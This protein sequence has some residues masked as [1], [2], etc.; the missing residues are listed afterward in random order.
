M[1]KNARFLTSLSFVLKEKH[2]K[3]VIKKEEVSLFCRGSFPFS[4][5][6][7]VIHISQCFFK[8]FLAYVNISFFIIYF[9]VLFR[10]EQLE[11]E[12]H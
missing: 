6:K 9:W 10:N 8:V 1:N 2:V 4:E 7:N 11:Q 12:V 5:G 3:D